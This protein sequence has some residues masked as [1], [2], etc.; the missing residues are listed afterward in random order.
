MLYPAGLSAVGEGIGSAVRAVIQPSTAGGY[1]AEI[2]LFYEPVLWL[3]AAASLLVRRDRLT[4]LDV[5]LASWV[6][7]GVIVSLFFGDGLPDHALWLTV[8]LVGLA[9]NALLMALV[10]DDRLGFIPPPSGARWVV[11]ASLIGVLCVF[12]LSFQALARSMVQA[13]QPALT[14]IQP[15][16]DSVVLVLVSLLFMVIGYFLFAS[17]WGSRTSWQGIAL[18]LAIFG[19]LTS[20]GAGWHAAV[21]AADNPVLFWHTQAISGTTPMLRATLY[22]I[23]DR[24]TGG[25]PNVTVAVMAPQD[26]VLAWLLRDFEHTRFINNPGDASDA[27]VILLPKSVDQPQFSTAYLGQKFII[28]RTWDA[29]TVTPVDFPGWWTQGDTRSVPGIVD[30]YVL[31]LRQDVYEG[32]DQGKVVG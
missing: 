4:T 15:P 20:L 29:S 32:L 5:F 18:G 16:A 25:W 6:L 8:P 24:T 13:P 17:L 1:A 27:E 19:S 12:T 7:V 21:A 31:W 9:A 23:S 22:E 26:G 11:A 10:P 3:L 14:M 28:S 2:A 30:E